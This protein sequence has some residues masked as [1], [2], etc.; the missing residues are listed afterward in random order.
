MATYLKE[1]KNST[2]ENCL[3]KKTAKD[4]DRCLERKSPSKIIQINAKPFK[5]K[6]FI[7]IFDDFPIII[8][9]DGTIDFKM[10]QS[11]PT[12]VLNKTKDYQI[13]LYDKNFFFPSISPLFV[14]RT[15]LRISKQISDFAVSFKV[16]Q[17]SF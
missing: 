9:E 14:P 10:N 2:V 12:L 1:T 6:R 13:W 3:V 4:F 17:I 5:K 15:S 7:S 8:P 16:N 11:N